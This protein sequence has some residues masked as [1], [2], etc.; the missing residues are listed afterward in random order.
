VDI[1]VPLLVLTKR[2]TSLVIHALHSLHGL[3]AFHG[4]E[5]DFIR[6]KFVA[7]DICVDDNLVAD[8]QV[9]QGCGGPALFKLGFVIHIYR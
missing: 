2:T 5:V 3:L 1:L 4:T 9:F 6:D 8:L 7:R